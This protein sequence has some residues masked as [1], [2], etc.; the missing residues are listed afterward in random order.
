MEAQVIEIFTLSHP[1]KIRII[2]VVA[3]L[4]K[5]THSSKMSGFLIKGRGKAYLEVSDITNHKIQ[6]G[7]DAYFK[8]LDLYLCHRISNNRDGMP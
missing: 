6:G 1:L 7:K 4:H 5:V 3:K 8:S 2:V